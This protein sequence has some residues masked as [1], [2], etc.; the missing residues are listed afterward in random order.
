MAEYINRDRLLEDME[1][2]GTF[3]G[4]AIG[5]F[6]I[7]MV[8]GAPAAKVAAV[9]EGAWINREYGT[10]VCSFCHTVEK[11]SSRARLHFC[12]TCGAKMDT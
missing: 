9:R 3:D 1:K 4:S 7:G 2:S 11:Q 6:A 10:M 8:R 5:Q 12:P